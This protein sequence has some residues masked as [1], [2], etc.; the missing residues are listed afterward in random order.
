LPFAAV[1]PGLALVVTIGLAQ[2]QDQPPP[3]QDQPP[4]TPPGVDVQARGPVH[5]A[6][7][8]PTAARPEAGPVVPKQPPDP[9]EEMP[10]D[11]KPEGNNVYWVPGYWSWDDETSDFLW[12]SGC[13]RD[14]PPGKVWMPGTWQQV[15]G[16]WEWSPGYW[17]DA[18]QQEVQYVPAPPPSI[19]TGPSTPQP[20]PDSTYVPGCWVYQQTR[21][22][23][24]PGFWCPFHADWCWTPAHY[25]RSPAGCIFVEGFWDHPLHAR[26]LLFAPV[27]L[28][29]N[30]LL[31]RQFAYRP[32]YVVQPDFLVGALFVGPN[33]NHYYF[34]DYFAAGHAQRGFT[35]WVDY[36]TS[37]ASYDPNF[38]YYRH[39]FAHDRT[40]ETNLRQ[41]YTARASG[42]V[43]R[44][45]ATLVQQTKVINNITVN[46][47]HN[48]TV[49]KTL[50]ITNVQNVHVLAPVTQVHNT[51]VTALAALGT[52]KAAPPALRRDVI[53]TTVVPKEH[54]AV[55]Q[56]H[57]QSTREVAVQR[58]QA[59]AKLVAT[60]VQ[61]KHID[62]ARPVKITPPPPKP[63]VKTPTP[64][65]VV[66]APPRP[67]V[68]AHVAQ[69]IPKLEPI[70]Q[71]LPPHDPKKVPPKK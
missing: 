8:E 18:Q 4:P 63:V 71:S 22:L 49:N 28:S 16:G 35:P 30:V 17:T 60:H 44:P 61:D 58:R 3:G 68:P 62:V 15:Q 36:R 39:T 34:G 25:V 48:V 64:H 57:V 7:A 26:G 32:Q 27:R 59:E 1:L 21:F 55:V 38:A 45:P 24:R 51:R 20:A 56:Q 37:R 69:A 31:N 47:V 29:A 67:Q 70:R 12:V 33:R 2:V 66:Q 53:K 6:F 23:W 42:V 46:K 40:W 50:N 5:E 9:I 43:A 52:A 54:H 13:W 41:L 11:Q 19:D 14:I 10:P 65:P